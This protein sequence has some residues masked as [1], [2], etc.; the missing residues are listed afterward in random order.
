MVKPRDFIAYLTEKYQMSHERA[1][2]ILVIADAITCELEGERLVSEPPAITRY[3]PMYRSAI[4]ESL[5][6][7]Y[8]IARKFPNP[9]TLGENHSKLID[10]LV[11]LSQRLSD[12]HLQTVARGGPGMPARLPKG[13]HQEVQLDKVKR[14]VEDMSPT[15]I[16]YW[17]QALKENP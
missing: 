1:H 12:Q 5:E 3:G 14:S 9:K 8:V 4:N 17:R 2:A 11:Y 6:T 7:P 16:D 10:F 13:M 15:A